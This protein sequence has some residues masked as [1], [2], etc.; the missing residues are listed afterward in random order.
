MPDTEIINIELLDLNRHNFEYGYFDNFKEKGIKPDTSDRLFPHKQMYVRFY[1]A[2]RSLFII[3]QFHD[4][5]EKEERNVLLPK[6][7]TG[8]YTNYDKTMAVYNNIIDNF[9]RGVQEYINF[10]LPGETIQSIMETDTYKIKSSFFSTMELNFFQLML[11][12]FSISEKTLKVQTDKNKLPLILKGENKYIILDEIL[13]RIF[14]IKNINL[15]QIFEANDAPYNCSDNIKYINNLAKINY[16]NM[17][18]PH[19]PYINNNT[20]TMS[21]DAD[22]SKYGISEITRQACN[23]KNNDINFLKTIAT[24]FDSASTSTTE[25]L[26]KRIQVRNKRQQFVYNDNVTFID[27]TNVKNSKSVKYILYL[28]G[29]KIIEYN[30]TIKNPT[31][32]TMPLKFIDF[33]NDDKAGTN[34]FKD[35]K[36]FT[37]MKSNLGFMNKLISNIKTFIKEYT[38]SDDTKL[39]DP[40]DGSMILDKF[41]AEP[42]YNIEKFKF[43]NKMKEADINVNTLVSLYTGLKTLYTNIK[44][45]ITLEEFTEQIFPGF[46]K[47]VRLD[48]DKFFEI[49][50]PT[51][52]ASEN[53]DII[54]NTI[55][56]RLLEPE[57]AQKLNASATADFSIFEKFFNKIENNLI[58]ILKLKS[59][60]KEKAEM[61]LKKTGT[62][63]ND[64]F[65]LSVDIVKQYLVTQY[66]FQ[67]FS[68]ILYAIHDLINEIE[69]T[70]KDERLITIYNKLFGSFVFDFNQNNSSVGSITTNLVYN[71]ENEL[72][73]SPA[74]PYILAHK[75]LGDFGQVVSFYTYDNYK[76]F[77]IQTMAGFGA[78]KRKE[79]NSNENK[80]SMDVDDEKIT[81]I[82]RSKPSSDGPRGKMVK[83]KTEATKEEAK[84]LSEIATRLKNEIEDF[85]C[86][87]INEDFS[88]DEY[89]SKAARAKQYNAIFPQDKLKFFITFDR[90]CSRISS[91]F[92]HATVYENTAMTL[93]PL[94]LFVNQCMLIDQSVITGSEILKYMSM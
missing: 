73:T 1:T 72:E 38:F 61:K 62:Q 83:N 63:Y 89:L 68:E 80:D 21:V 25:S 4:F 42:P 91:L 6:I 13:L 33:V 77:D 69:Q 82:K 79:V 20:L 57:D 28:A 19:L 92:N 40:N 93:S 5:L 35:V 45:K 49:N 71:Y 24:K 65:N 10:M 88:D 90:I 59:D 67:E 46:M 44:D 17:Y 27:N 47:V 48:I 23:L 9:I 87:T 85:S 55:K 39:H 3:D 12:Y 78:K 2:F 52:S 94:E 66:S 36:W 58:T 75:T 32:L 16:N 81:K 18:F 64:K 29:Y 30:Y 76:Y 56:T 50:R 22:K 74:V 60:N 15:E 8:K 41:M 86:K 70:V 54:I 34:Y 84:K 51:Y 14:S 31:N 53:I 26:L 7:Q 43:P 37:N 11:K